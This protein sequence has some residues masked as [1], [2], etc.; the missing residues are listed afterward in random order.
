MINRSLVMIQPM[1]YIYSKQWREAERQVSN[2]ILINTLLCQNL[3]ASLEMHT[4]QRE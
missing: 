2:H 1:I 3:A 4:P